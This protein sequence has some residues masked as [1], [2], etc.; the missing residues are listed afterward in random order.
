MSKSNEIVPE[1]VM[2]Q[3]ETIRVS[4][5]FNMNDFYS[6]QRYAYDNEFYDFVNFTENNSKQYLK[7]LKYYSKW[8]GNIK[9]KNG[10]N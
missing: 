7:I 3:Y 8:V 4:G 2:Q 5:M 9:Y 10:E 1:I 6:V